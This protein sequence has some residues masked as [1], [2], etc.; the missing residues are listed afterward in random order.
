MEVRQSTSRKRDK[1]QIRKGTI[2]YKYCLEP[3]E[4]KFIGS[5]WVH[6]PLL[7]LGT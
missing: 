5:C 3:V 7:Q 2:C 1:V 6:E 4:A